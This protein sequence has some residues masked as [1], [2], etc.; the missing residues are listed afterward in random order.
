MTSDEKRPSPKGRTHMDA[1]THRL[2]LHPIPLDQDPTG[3]VRI[4]RPARSPS[5]PPLD[6]EPGPVTPD[7]AP[8]AE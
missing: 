7:R 3:G 2:V 5:L 8:D 1:I 4:G 6:D